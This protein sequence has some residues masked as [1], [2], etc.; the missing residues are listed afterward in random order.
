MAK[1][2]WIT[3]DIAKIL[4]KKVE[5]TK[6]LFFSGGTVPWNLNLSNTQ[7]L[8]YVQHVKY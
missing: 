6:E 1:S 3:V 5:E 4:V 2:E 7:V 8:R